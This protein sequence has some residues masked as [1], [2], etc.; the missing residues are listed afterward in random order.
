MDFL[1]VDIFSMC[2]FSSCPPIAGVVPANLQTGTRAYGI[3]T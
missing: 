1:N 3:D 2:S